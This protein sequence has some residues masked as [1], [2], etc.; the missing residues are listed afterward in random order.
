MTHFPGP[1][2]AIKAP[3]GADTFEVSWPGGTSSKIPNQ[4]L[5]GYCPCAG[6]QGHGGEITFQPG[7]N[8]ELR[9]IKP[10]GNYALELSWGDSHSSGIYTFE[11]LWH[12]GRLIQE[13]G[14]EELIGLKRLPPRP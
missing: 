12:L 3:H 13:M 11:Y 14:V 5:R 4:V 6:C 1:P 10:V 9:D 7:R 2:T 8:S